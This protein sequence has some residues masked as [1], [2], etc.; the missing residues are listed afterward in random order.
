MASSGSTRRRIAIVG[1][2]HAGL[3]AGHALLQAGHEITLYSDRT[4]EQWLLASRPTGTATRFA[5]AL[6]FER[7]LGLAHWEAVAPRVEGA[8]F[9][10]S[11]SA[12]R[13][14]LTVTAKGTTYG[15]AVDL[16]LQSHRWM[17][18]LATAGAEVVIDKIDIAKLDAIA[19]RNELVL[20]A[21]GRGPLAELF[22]RHAERS[23]Y[24]APQRNLAMAIVT[25]VAQA[26]D[27]LP[28]LPM[29]FDV[30]TPYGELFW[31]PYHHRDH[32]PTWSVGFEARPGG[33]M[34]RFA[35]CATGAQVVEIGRQVIRE[36]VPWEIGWTADME[37]ADPEGW[38]VGA[39]TPT[40]HDPVGRLPSGRVVMPVGDAAIAVD[41]IAGQGAN[42]GNKLVQQIVA[43]IAAGPDASFD[44]AW[45]TRTFEAFWA[46]HGAPAI[47]L[48]NLFLAP[49]SA[50]FQRLLI[51]QCGSDGTS[52]TPHQ[53]IANALF[54]NIVDPRR[55]T[56]AFL[57]RSAA[58]Q[59]I[60]ELSGRSWFRQLAT[61][62]ARLGVR[63][64]RQLFAPRV[65]QP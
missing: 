18:D 13:Q 31:V 23:G 65:A 56:G 49:P 17:R 42:L 37:L 57:H 10:V 35:R 54:E 41:P 27:G 7:S 12:G 40:V 64:L 11:S 62:A 36:L 22:P 50:A 52:D 47:A 2:G 46:D 14:A 4:P 61:G 21:S 20:V 8:H 5:S 38:L 48:T 24:A 33:A 32:G 28:F 26:V 15:Q 29:R 3:V 6:A 53:R 55:S 25:G 9:T 63:Q 60:A 59:L 19:A 51:A 44:A 16:R 43:A 58:N 30:L 45:M 1:S 39:I 34:D